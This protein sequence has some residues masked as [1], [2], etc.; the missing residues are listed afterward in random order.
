MTTRKIRPS[1]KRAVS[2][3]ALNDEPTCL[4]VEEVSS[5]IS[6][7]LVADMFGKEP[8]EVARM[9]VDTRRKSANG[10]AT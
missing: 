3:I 1:L 4:D 5:L 7:L 10:S 6:T 8:E 2:W 9:I